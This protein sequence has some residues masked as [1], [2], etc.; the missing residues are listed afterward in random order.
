MIRIFRIQIIRSIGANVNRQAR[1]AM[2]E[3]TE[4]DATLSNDEYPDIVTK[5]AKMT[6]R[7]WA[8]H[9]ARPVEQQ[10]G[11]ERPGCQCNGRVEFM[12]EDS[13][14]MTES[15]NSEYEDTADRDSRSCVENRDYDF[16]GNMTRTI[17]TPPPRRNRRRRYKVRKKYETDIEDSMFDTSDDEFLSEEEWPISEHMFQ[18]RRVADNVDRTIRNRNNNSGCWSWPGSDNDYTSDEDSNLADRP[19]TNLNTAGAG[20][21]YNYSSVEHVKYGEIPVTELIPVRGLDTEE[22]L[23]LR[24]ST[25]TTA[26]SEI[27]TSVCTETGIKDK[28]EIKD[29][30]GPEYRG[31]GG[32]GEEKYRKRQTV[33]TD[34]E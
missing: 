16:S 25:I 29:C 7:A 8:E 30:T 13:E 10:T 32:G 33:L 3:M 31:G 6:M 9:D 17:Y 1:L 19:V 11:C 2:W 5:I 21:E 22:Q 27:E 24:V 34:R 4:N 26:L 14:D 18:P 20:S 28:P 12:D 23:T 15:D